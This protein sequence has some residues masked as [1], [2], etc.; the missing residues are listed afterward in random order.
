MTAKPILPGELAVR[1]IEA[2]TD[3]YAD[4]AG[5]T[6]ALGFIDSMEKAYRRPAG[7]RVAILREGFGN[8]RHAA[9]AT[10]TLSISH[11]LCR[12]R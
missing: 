1:D 10:E 9:T 12:A 6:I 8:S 5:D 11:L 7:E 4:Q 2:A 3:F